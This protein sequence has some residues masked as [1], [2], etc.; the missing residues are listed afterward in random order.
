MKDFFDQFL[1]EFGS[2]MSICS[3][4]GGQGKIVRS[5]DMPED[6]RAQFSSEEE[7]ICCYCEACNEYS[8]VM[9]GSLDLAE[10]DQPKRLASTTPRNA[11]CPCG[12]GKKYKRCCGS[13]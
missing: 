5:Q 13:S 9:G 3:I 7:V 1:N 6:V 12:S 11:P 2:E 10:V 4:C 8:P